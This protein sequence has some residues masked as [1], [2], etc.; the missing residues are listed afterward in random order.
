MCQAFKTLSLEIEHF[1]VPTKNVFA[2][3][4]RIANWVL[5][6]AA[7]HNAVSHTYISQYFSKICKLVYKK[8]LL[9][10]LL[11]KV[12]H[13][14]IWEVWYCS[15]EVLDIL[16]AVGILGWCRQCL[17]RW[18]RWSHWWVAW[19]LHH[20]DTNRSGWNKDEV[21]SLW[22]INSLLFWMKLFTDLEVWSLW[23]IIQLSRMCRLEEK[24]CFPPITIL[25]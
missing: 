13:G 22:G 25:L 2:A 10:F 16:K 20:R 24:T 9:K 8:L 12:K 5:Q 6:R 14:T 11:N 18:Q 4:T 21:Q 17:F 1:D 23:Q 7:T 15:F 3:G 19:D